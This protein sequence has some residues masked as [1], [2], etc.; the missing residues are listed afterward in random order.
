MGISFKI[1]AAEGIVYAMAEGSIGAAD[2]LA[3]RKDLRADPKFHT[4]LAE[5]IEFRMSLLTITDEEAKALA[6]DRPGDHIRKVAIVAVGS[7]RNWALR[8]QEI[9]VDKPV[10]VFTDLGSAKKWLISD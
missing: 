6:F 9:S 7:N 10:E 2:I 4:D 5:I 8:Y 3:Y 1:D